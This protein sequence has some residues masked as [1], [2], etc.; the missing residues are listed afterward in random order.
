MNA[1]LLNYKLDNDYNIAFI[2]FLFKYI[3]K[4]IIIIILFFMLLKLKDSQFIEYNCMII[5]VGQQVN[6]IKIGNFFH[7]FNKLYF[8]SDIIY[9]NYSFYYHGIQNLFYQ[10]H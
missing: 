6:L 5:L 1:V 2:T 8:F 3:V 4:K 9:Y 7:L 10:Y